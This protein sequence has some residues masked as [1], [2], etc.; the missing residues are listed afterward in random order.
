LV[1]AKI[2]KLL[3]NRNIWGATLTTIALLAF[4]VQAL[5]MT[6]EKHNQVLGFDGAFTKLTDVLYQDVVLD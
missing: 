1:V 4:T 3:K 2:K 6:V 5:G